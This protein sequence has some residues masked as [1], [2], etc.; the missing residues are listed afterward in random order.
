MTQ[1]VSFYCIPSS[2]TNSGQSSV[3]AHQKDGTRRHGFDS[4]AGF[5]RIVIF[6]SKPTD[7]GGLPLAKKTSQACRRPDAE[8]G[9]LRRDQRPQ[10][11]QRREVGGGPDRAGI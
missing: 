5:S 4:L 7:D 10:P 3:A 2:R 11:R 1:S 9:R 6:V 8:R